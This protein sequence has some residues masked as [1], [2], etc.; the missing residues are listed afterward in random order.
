MN[1]AFSRYLHDEDSPETIQKGQVR[2]VVR[3]SLS[4]YRKGD[5]DKELLNLIAALAM[6]MEIHSGLEK[7]LERKIRRFS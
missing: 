5:I 6:E 3:H 7:K 2:D 1:L 4:L